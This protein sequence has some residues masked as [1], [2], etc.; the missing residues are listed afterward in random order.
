[1]TLQEAIDAFVL[2]ANAK[3]KEY[4]DN[5]KYTSAPTH[6]IINTSSQWAKIVVVD[7]QH[8]GTSKDGSVYAFVAMKD[9]QTKAL[10]QIKTG[11]IHRPASYNAPAKHARGNVF[12]PNFGNAVNQF[13][14]RYL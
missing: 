7:N 5:Q 2:H 3:T 10:G 13:S 12:L 1:M 8:N 11:D 6:R 9:G 4:W 14:I